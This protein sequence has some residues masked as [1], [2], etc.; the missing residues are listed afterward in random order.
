MAIRKDNVKTVADTRF[1]RVFDL[2]YEEGAHYYDASRRELENIA[3]IKSENDFNSMLPDAVSGFL[4][5]KTPDSEPRLLLDY[6]YRYPTGQYMLSI[7]AGLVDES[8]KESDQPLFTAMKREIYEETGIMLK[9]TDDIRMVNPLV[10]NSPGF[11]D[12][13][14]ALIA[15]TAHLDDLSEL[16]QKGAVGSEKF[17]G[18]LL[19][20]REEVLCLLREGKDPHGHRY[21]MVTWCAMMYFVSD[22]WKA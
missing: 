12:E 8:D 2:Q 7:P 16:N 21:P 18:F 5:I 9:V 20:T 15:M 17:A 4:V 3:A 6:E 11:T 14:T 13:C 10:F 22:L 19:A 1:V